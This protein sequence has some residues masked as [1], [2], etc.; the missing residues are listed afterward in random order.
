M[1]KKENVSYIV[2]I[3]INLNLILHLRQVCIENIYICI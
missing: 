1:H 2:N 3:T